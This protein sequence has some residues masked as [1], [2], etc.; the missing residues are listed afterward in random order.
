MPIQIRDGG[1]ALPPHMVDAVTGVELPT[2]GHF[3]EIGFADPRITRVVGEGRLV[4]RAVTVRVV[5]PDSALVHR[6]T[7]LLGSGDVLVVDIGGDR[8][9]API[10]AV[11][12]TA[13]A[14]SGAAGIVIDGPCT[15]REA[16]GSLGIPI[17]ARGTSA[18]TTKLHALDAGGINVPIVIGGVA[19]L[20]GY[21]VVG[22]ADGL[23]LADPADV[24][25]VIED[26]RRSD[27]AEPQKLDRLRS[28]APLT[29]VSRAGERLRGVLEQQPRGGE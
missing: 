1:P 27:A 3:L 20:L 13:V 28:R 12:G 7:E 15:D 2:L 18:L 5:A 6:A 29:T 14:A 22:D 26:A 19:V 25:S 16:L 11:V 17:Y 10:G 9:H 8:R 4:G 21:L 23:L 24:D